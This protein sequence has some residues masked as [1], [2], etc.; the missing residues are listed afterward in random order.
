MLFCEVKAAFISNED[1]LKFITKKNK[2]NIF[3][4]LITSVKN[5]T[6]F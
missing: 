4:D 1:D 2:K 3:N 5:N 6:Q